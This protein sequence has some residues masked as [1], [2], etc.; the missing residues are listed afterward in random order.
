M[1][2][3]SLHADHDDDAFSLDTLA[4]SALSRLCLPSC[5]RKWDYEWAAMYVQV[6][7]R[8]G[9]VQSGMYVLRIS[10]LASLPRGRTCV[11]ASFG[12]RSKDVM[13]D[14]SMPVRCG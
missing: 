4:A 9:T 7:G 6:V 13:R 11:D 12:R 8:S 14:R 2:G 10:L 1:I 3:C 5:Y